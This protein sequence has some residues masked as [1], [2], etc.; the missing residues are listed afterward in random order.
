MSTLGSLLEVK[1]EPN[2]DKKTISFPAHVWTTVLVD[3]GI[4]DV[5]GGKIG[6]KACPKRI[7]NCVR[8]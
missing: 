6:S 4:I 8:F 3:F 5:K 2:S 7:L 1:M